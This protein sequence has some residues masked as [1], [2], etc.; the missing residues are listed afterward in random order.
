MKAALAANPTMSSA[1]V[2][3]TT[4]TVV[5]FTARDRFKVS[6]YIG[7]DHLVARVDTWVPNPT[8]GDTLIRTD[9]TAYKDF[10]GVKVPT[11]V[12]QAQGGYP[13]LDVTLGD[14]KPNAAVT[15]QAPMGGP[16]AARVE[17]ETFADGV[18]YLRGTPDPNSQLV[19]FKD[20][21]VIVESSV[22]EGRALA[23]IAE[24]KRLA[25]GKPVQ[26]GRAHV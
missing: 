7:P 21:T 16:Q 5:S 24:A 23:N 1:K 18:W 6:G 10:G 9:Y 3:G 2:G 19:E 11:H 8:L 15:L 22:T 25:P 14:A 4:F 26:I 20:F 12:V 17:S 13:V